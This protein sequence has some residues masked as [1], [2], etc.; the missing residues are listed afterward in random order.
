MVG[1]VVQ[2]VRTR[3]VWKSCISTSAVR[4]VTGNMT[5]CASGPV[6]YRGANVP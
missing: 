4:M 3:V 1:L 5:C 2:V 6:C